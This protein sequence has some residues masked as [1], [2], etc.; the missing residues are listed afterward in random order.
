MIRALL[1]FV[2]AIAGCP[3]EAQSAKRPTCSPGRFLLDGGAPLLPSGVMPTP[4]AVTLAGSGAV[5]VASGCSPTRK[6][7]LRRM[8]KKTALR[9]RWP[10]GACAGASRAVRLVATIDPTCASMRGKL[11]GSKLRRTFRATRSACGDGI[12]DRDGLENCEPPGPCDATCGAGVSLDA[13]GNGL[14]VDALTSFHIEAGVPKDEIDAEPGGRRVARTILDIGFAPGATVAQALAVLEAL[15]GRIVDMVAGVSVV[16]VRVPDPG[17]LTGLDALAAT[18]AAMPGVAFVNKGYFSEDDLPSNFDAGLFLPPSAA[19]LAKIGHHLG[20]RAHAAWNTRAA[21]VT[22]SQPAVVVA[23]QFGDGPPSDALAARI[24]P[25]DFKTVEGFF[26]HGYFLLGVLVGDFGGPRTDRGFVT[27]MFPAEDF[28]EGLDIRVVDRAVRITDAMTQSR[29]ID[30]IKNT[31]GRV[32]VNTSYGYSSVCNPEGINCRPL[33]QITSEAQAW[34][35]RVND[36]GIADRYLHFTSAGNVDHDLPNVTNAASNG[37]FAAAALIVA[38]PLA[39]TVVVENARGDGGP[40]FAARCVSDES[41]VGG[42]LAGIGTDVWSLD[43]P[44]E[45][46]GASFRFGTS[47]ATP[48]VAGLAAL[49]WTIAPQLAPEQIVDTLRATSRELP[50]PD[51]PGC[52]ARAPF[53]APR[54]VIDAYEAVLSLDAA[55]QPT[56]AAAPV[57]LALLDV[58]GD[59]AFDAADLQQFRDRFV[60]GGTLAPDPVEPDF[61]RFDLNGDGFTGG[62]R[63][64]PFDLDRVGST[65]FG[66]PTLDQLVLQKLVADDRPI[67]G[68]FDERAVSDLDIVCYYA[69]SDLFTGTP[70][71]RSALLPVDLCNP[72]VLREQ[73]P[74][75]LQQNVPVQLAIRAGILQRDGST[76]DFRAGVLIHLAPINAT[77]TPTDGVSAE[78]SPGQ[79]PAFTTTVT[80]AIADGV[81]DIAVEVRLEAGGPVIAAG[82]ISRVIGV[83]TSSATLESFV[84]TVSASATVLLPS[85]QS[86]SDAASARAEFDDEEGLTETSL[87][88]SVSAS[89][90]LSEPGCIAF[91]NTTATIDSAVTFAPGGAF[92]RLAF[93]GSYDGSAKRDFVLNC[94]ADARPLS[95]TNIRFVI[96]GGT[97]P[98]TLTTMLAATGELADSV[99]VTLFQEL[100]AFSRVESITSPAAGTN[101]GT[102]RAGTYRLLVNMGGA[103]ILPNPLG[104]SLVM[105]SANATVT[106]TLQ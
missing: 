23:D 35:R 84:A 13:P 90:M 54:R 65:R 52:T 38:P 88:T 83:T 85:S 39:N 4:E 58:T 6:V 86:D 33:D 104:A 59:G 105:G 12:L 68:G 42:T 61:G 40:S 41:F 94:E 81:V 44:D 19:P 64:A 69:H 14:L 97:V 67:F 75:T 76:V 29:I 17:S 31:P 10:K 43:G 20:V 63:A 77:V 37:P 34:V 87:A 30:L 5:S 56:P 8:G 102:L 48:Q 1:Y 2:L 51:G 93:T 36:A 74:T 71:A 16:V 28:A 66:A 47:Y 49:L 53:L 24:V 22:G 9:A 27:G 103:Q 95:A 73:L 91:G 72:W 99:N 26:S 78:I 7:K 25:A 92:T 60:V 3:I 82:T 96:P 101:Q 106:F 57:R 89:A 45:A 80:P 79:P 11:T 62:N 100:P 32:V 70:A 18:A 98:Y 15:G 55:A 21:L 50:E 46:V